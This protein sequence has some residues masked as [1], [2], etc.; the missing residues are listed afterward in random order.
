MEFSRQGDWSGLPF[1]A[2]G[3]LPGPRMEPVSLALAGGFCTTV[4][5]GKP[6]VRERSEVSQPSVFLHLFIHPFIHSFTK[7]SE[8]GALGTQG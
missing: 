3:D 7:Q 4:P 8:H 1:L 2:L 6:L 5:P